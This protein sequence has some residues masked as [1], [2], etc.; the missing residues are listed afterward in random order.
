M[1]KCRMH[2]VVVESSVL[3]N[4]FIRM[5]RDKSLQIAFS[6]ALRTLRK[7]QGFTQEGLAADA[8]MSR[9]HVSALESGEHNPTLYTMFTLCD[10]LGIQFVVMAREVQTNYERVKSK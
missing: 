10:L 8:G 7:R 9:G 6:T 4:G 1:P 3:H 5:R 2:R